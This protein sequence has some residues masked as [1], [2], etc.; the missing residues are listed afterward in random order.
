MR[1]GA[2]IEGCP[3][4]MV[5]KWETFSPRGRMILFE[6]NFD[7]VS[8]QK[9]IF[10]CLTCGKCRVLCPISI[11]VYEKME[12][13]RKELR[14]LRLAPSRYYFISESVRKFKNPFGGE[15]EKPEFI[16]KYSKIKKADVIYYPGCTSMY[17]E[18][19]LS[20]SV[21]E[22]LEYLKIDFVVESEYC[23][24]STALRTGDEADVAE[25]NFRKLQSVVD[26]AGAKTI[27][28]SCPG[29]YRT[30]KVS[31]DKLF[32]GLNCEVMH[33][34]QFLVDKIDELKL[35]KME[36][37]VTFHDSCHLGRGMCVYEEPRM[38][39]K[40]VADI[41][42]MERNREYSLCCGGGGGIRVAYKDVSNKIRKIRAEEAL[43]TGADILVTSCPYCY[44]N[45]KRANKIEVKD[46]FELISESISKSIRER[47]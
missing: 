9:S 16:L 22:I 30:M 14:K 44:L 20:K 29:C 23:C 1:C 25:P 11:E 19:V 37:I 21:I 35:N 12:K 28:T 45:L 24:G 8:F 4:Y 7:D 46:L 18:K 17:R 40:Q 33:V 34:S 2:C 26:E 5:T 41:V 36:K 27:I 39:L 31:Y 42:E 15:F 3:I 38:L 6:E 47:I 10:T 43:K 32:G 13:K